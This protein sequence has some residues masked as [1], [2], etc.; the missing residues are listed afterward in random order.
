MH[1][2]KIPFSVPYSP[3]HSFIFLTYG[4]AADD[5]DDDAGGGNDVW[6]S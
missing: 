6:F 5:D 3:W 4:L 2:Q 1:T